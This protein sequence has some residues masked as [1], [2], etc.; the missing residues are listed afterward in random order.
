MGWADSLFANK[1][2]KYYHLAKRQKIA[3]ARLRRLESDVA[4][5]KE[6]RRI[7]AKVIR[8]LNYH[9]RTRVPRSAYSSF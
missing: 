6:I 7:I 1:P 8:N 3:K 4:E 9:P 5:R 2:A